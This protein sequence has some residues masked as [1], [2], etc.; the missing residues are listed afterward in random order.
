[1]DWVDD[2][3]TERITP[4][5]DRP[6]LSQTDTATLRETALREI[7]DVIS[8]SRDDEK[9]VFDAI[10]ENASRLC[11]APLAFL[12]LVD[13]ARTIVT[14]PASRGARVGFSEILEQFSEPVDRC[15]LI[16]V[17]PIVNGEIIRMDDIA[18]DDLYRDRDPRRIQMVEIEGVRSVVA[19]PL[20]RGNQAIGAIILYRQ[21]M[22]PYCR[23][24]LSRPSSRSRTPD[25]SVNWKPDSSAKR[26][27]G[28]SWRSFQHLAMTTHQYLTSFSKPQPDYATR[29]LP[30]CSLPTTIV[31]RC[32][33][34]PRT[35]RG[36]NSST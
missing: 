17:G 6:S 28:R 3:V 20:Q 14:V 16:A 12:S 36:Q 4:D 32:P 9:P 23:A 33:W 1:M 18:D 27:R 19:V 7:L 11:D 13:D 35:E 10:L 15:E 8:R 24:L 34:S 30:V 26:Q 31:H 5:D 22:F 2:L 21:T 29:R 25:S